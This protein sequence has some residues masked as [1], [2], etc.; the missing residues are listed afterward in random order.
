MY[1]V[2]SALHL[3]SYPTKGL[4]SVCA[5]IL[6]LYA[7]IQRIDTWWQGLSIPIKIAESKEIGLE[8][9]VHL[10]PDLFTS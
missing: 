2:V 7:A 8:S 5:T 1:K 3:T 10:G 6:K 9:Y 4:W